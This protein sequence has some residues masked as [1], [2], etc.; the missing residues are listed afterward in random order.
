MLCGMTKGIY[1]NGDDDSTMSSYNE[2]GKV[3]AHKYPKFWPA[4]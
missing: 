1:N 2:P 3:L 4:S